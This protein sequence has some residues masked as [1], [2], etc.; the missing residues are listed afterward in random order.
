[1]HDRAEKK[2]LLRKG[3][4]IG[5]A[6]INVDQGRIYKLLQEGFSAG[7]FETFCFLHFK[8]VHGEFTPGQ[9]QTQRIVLLMK[10]CD[11]QGSW[12]KL[13]DLCLEET[14]FVYD[15]HGPYER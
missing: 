11:A 3:A 9:V 14:A 10:H 7:D 6:S 15:K 2:G 5:Q 8:E 12:Q 1:L 13:L 4:E